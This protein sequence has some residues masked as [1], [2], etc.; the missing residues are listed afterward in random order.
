[1]QGKARPPSVLVS[2]V[3][4]VYEVFKTNRSGLVWPLDKQIAWHH[5]AVQAQVEQLYYGLAVAVALNRTIILPQV[6]PC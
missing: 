2:Q 1:M 3:P 5:A 4:E 6:R